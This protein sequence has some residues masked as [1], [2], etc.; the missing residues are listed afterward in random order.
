MQISYSRNDK[1]ISRKFYQYL[2]PTVLMVLAMQFGSLADAIVIGNF[3]GDSFLSASSLALPAIFLVEIPAMMIGTGASIVAA[4]FIG[5]RQVMEASKT[6]KLSLFLAFVSGLVFV[7]IAIFAADPISLLFAGNYPNLAPMISQYMQAYAYQSPIIGVGIVVAYFLPSDNHPNLGAAFFVVS[8]VVHIASEI[9]FCLFL[10]RSVAMWGVAFSMGI[11]M[12]AGLAVLVPYL[13]SK[14]R[15]VDLKVPFKGAFSYAGGL[16]KAGSAAGVLTGLSFV[17][18]LVLNLAATAYLSEAEIPVFAMLSNFAFVVDLFLI[19]VLQIM[20]SV[21]SSLHGEKDYFAVRSV[22]KRVLI[23]ATGVTLALLTVSVVFPELF[24]II[25]GVDLQAVRAGMAPGMPD[26]LLVVRVYCIS[27]LFYAANRFVVYYYPSILV[28]SPALLNNAIRVGLIGPIVIYFLMWSQ[29][30]LGNAIGV[31]IMEA[32]TLGVTLAFILIGKKLKRFPGTGLLLLPKDDAN[33]KVLDISIPAAEHEIS[34]AIEEL[35]RYATELSHSETSGAMLAL[36]SE[37]IIA[38]VIAYGYKRKA[39]THFIDVRVCLVEE[40][41]LVRIR[42]DGIA[43]DPTTYQTD[44]EDMR[45]SGIEV[46]R[47][48]ASEFKY[49]RVLNTNNTIMVITING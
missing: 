21:V 7:P 15:A 45:Y 17:Y 13:C 27:F 36:A 23:I 32:A 2:I 8:N 43:F 1:L 42:D 33:Q 34:K 3:L 16:L 28:N 40:G 19:G 41:L 18:Y 31:I 4:N 48:V 11:G 24:F 47:K 35:Q 37:E 26:P 30:V 46:I 44:E 14:K 9:L 6:F 20:P 22:V 39:G 12:F 5:K 29:G 49:L 38:N 25:F 10:D